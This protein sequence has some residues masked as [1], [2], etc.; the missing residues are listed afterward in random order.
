MKKLLIALVF[1]VTLSI[2]TAAPA[3]AHVHAVTPLLDCGQADVNAGG[4][5]TNGT[6][7]DDATGGPITG[8]IP[9]DTGSSPLTFGDG[10]FGAAD[11]HCP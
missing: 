9:R 6:P 10:G 7:A 4:N 1:V 3:F 8:L 11:G 2:A 5:G